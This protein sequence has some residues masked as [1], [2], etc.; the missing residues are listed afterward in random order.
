M[1]LTLIR[2]TTASTP[3]PFREDVREP[4]ES[5]VR[6]SDSNSQIA[7]SSNC[8][9]GML[10]DGDRKLCDTLEPIGIVPLGWYR[11]SLTYSPRFKRPLPLLQH[12]P[13]HSGIRIH[14]GNTLHDTAGCILVGTLVH[15]GCSLANARQAEQLIVKLLQNC[16]PHEEHFIEI[17]TPDYR[18]AE[19]ECMQ[20]LEE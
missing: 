2:K 11:L 19:L 5:V 18:N 9:I 1:K 8:Q 17:A 7:K 13:G 15:D 16:P 10:F 3:R 12:V 6:Y 20:L 4:D 14:A